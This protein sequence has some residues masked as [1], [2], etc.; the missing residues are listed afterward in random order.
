MKIEGNSTSMIKL[1]NSNWV[2]WK[3]MMEDF[4]TIKDLLDT[5]EGEESKPKDI[6]YLEWNKM[7]KKIIASI[8]QWIDTSSR[9]HVANEINAYN[10]WKK[11]ESV[12]E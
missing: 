12:F 8:R 9:H 5:L 10:L 2:I 3:S 4:L 6:S 1:N 11:L 7:K